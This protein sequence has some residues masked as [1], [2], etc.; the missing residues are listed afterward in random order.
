MGIALARRP[1]RSLEALR[2]VAKE[3]T[4]DGYQIPPELA[5][6]MRQLSAGKGLNRITGADLG[7]IAR[8]AGLPAAVAEDERA[9][10]EWA[11]VRRSRERFKSCQEEIPSLERVAV[12]KDAAAPVEFR[13]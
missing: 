9:G 1:L 10:T 4:R 5:A 2:V 8:I 13:P 12:F 3:V 7:R 6:V 11:G